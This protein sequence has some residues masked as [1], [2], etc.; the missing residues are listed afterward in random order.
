MGKKET[1]LALLKVLAAA[2]WADGR[3]DPE[4][5]N[6]I[7][8]KALRAGLDNDDLSE[9]DAILSQPIPNTQCEDLTRQLLQELRSDAD[10]QE[11]VE[12]LEELFESDGEVD[13][14]EQRLLHELRGV[15]A[16][17]SAL[18]GFLSRVTGVFR[19]VFGSAKPGP[20][21]LTRTLSNAVVE[22]LDHLSQGKWTDYVDPE[23][24][25]RHTLY[26]AVLGKVADIHQGK[27]S[28]E[29]ERIGALMHERRGLEP[30]L[31]DWLVEAVRDAVTGDM[32]RQ[33]LLAEFN[34]EADME[35]RKDL[36]DAAFAVAAADGHLAEAELTELRLIS[37]YL[38]IDA[39]DFN[40]VRAKWNKEVS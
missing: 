1:R 4:E 26:A 29:M 15:M 25:N 31:L 17:A 39:R 16:T 2:A 18:D 9:I 6:H 20:G 37:N 30:P 28:E 27:S 40:T 32:D 23:E 22:R 24:L 11:A 12:T 8:E 34:R 10:R 33:R 13:E 5:V 7:K 35:D 21:A 14:N 3:V 38:W 36:L 19:G